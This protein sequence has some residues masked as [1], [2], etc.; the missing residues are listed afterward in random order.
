MWWL[1]GILAV[2]LLAYLVAMWFRGTE[3][4]NVANNI[5]LAAI[6]YESHSPE[7]RKEADDMLKE[8]LAANP[9]LGY[10]FEELWKP[11]SEATRW[12]WYSIAFA[13]NGVSPAHHDSFGWRPSKNVL[14]EI[15]NIRKGITDFEDKLSRREPY[16][17]YLTW[18]RV[19]N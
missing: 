17:K 16:E 15:I 9:R 18:L 10:T 1:I 7:R 6:T 12:R 4:Y 14:H 13:F 2:I 8:T 11:D 3:L 19:R 5:I